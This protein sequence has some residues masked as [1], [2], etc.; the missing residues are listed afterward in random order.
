M[1]KFYVLLLRPAGVFGAKYNAPFQLVSKKFDPELRA[2][3][4]FV[5]YASI[6]KAEA[7]A[8]KIAKKIFIYDHTKRKVSF[9]FREYRYQIIDGE[10]PRV[11]CHERLDNRT[12]EVVTEYGT[13]EDAYCLNKND[14]EEHPSKDCIEYQYIKE[15]IVKR[16]KIDFSNEKDPSNGEVAKR[17]LDHKKKLEAYLSDPKKYIHAYVDR[18][19]PWS[20]FEDPKNALDTIP[21]SSVHIKNFHKDSLN[22]PTEFCFVY[23]TKGCYI[24]ATSRV[25]GLGLNPKSR[26]TVWLCAHAKC[27]YETKVDGQG[28]ETYVCTPKVLPTKE[29][30]ILHANLIGFA[31][32][33]VF[34][35]FITNLPDYVAKLVSRTAYTADD[36][37]D[38]RNFD[39]PPAEVYRLMVIDGYLKPVEKFMKTKKEEGEGVVAKA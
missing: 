37:K 3:L 14:G 28:F 22:L 7:E 16:G 30:A 2:S 19:C 24:P 17:A 12:R 20:G 39:I 29:E 8:K 33:Q 26:K 15:V 32:P 11:I 10:K 35:D 23:P 5:P 34:E 13:F 31:Q 25:L 9:D 1:S 38:N 21:D 27:V 18:P 36:R 4:K 6:E